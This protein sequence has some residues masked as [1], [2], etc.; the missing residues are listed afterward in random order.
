MHVGA[1][2]LDQVEVTHVREVLPDR[3]LTRSAQT[4]Q[5]GYGLFAIS[6]RSEDEEP[7]G[8]AQPPNRLW[9]MLVQ[10]LALRWVKPRFGPWSTACLWAETCRST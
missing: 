1:A 6:Q 5:L 4:P 8:I 10:A 7:L 3:R 9:L 2:A